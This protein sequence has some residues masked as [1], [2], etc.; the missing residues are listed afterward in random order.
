MNEEKFTRRESVEAL[1][2]LAVDAHYWNSFDPERAAETVLNCTETELREYQSK[3]PEDLRES[4]EERYLDL[5]RKWLYALSRCASPMVTGP[6]KFP[7]KRMQKA[8][9]AERN[10]R[11]RLDEWAQKFVYRVTHPTQ[12]R[13]TG[14]AEIERLQMKVDKLTEFQDLMKKC[15]VII[16]KKT[17]TDEEKVDEM[18]MLGLGKATA[19]AQLEPDFCGRVGFPSYALTNNL[20]KIKQAQSRIDMLTKMVSKENRE[21]GMGWG[22]IELDYQEERIRLHFDEIP[23]AELRTTL[24]HNAFKWS[25]TNQAW[26]RQLTDNAIRATKNIFGLE[27]L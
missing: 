16:R 10:A 12:H 22:T 6:A 2:K 23:N 27:T 26:Q 4:F 25:R 20:A 15:N 3:L 24:K 11:K 17:L 5:T 14:W 19:K 1:K 7:V 21:V 13:L 9:E 8:N 18:M